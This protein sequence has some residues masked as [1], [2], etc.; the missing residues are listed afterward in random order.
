MTHADIEADIKNICRFMHVCVKLLIS[1][2]KLR[3]PFFKYT[4]QKLNYV[5]KG[6]DRLQS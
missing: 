3:L 1:S 2:L 5:L 4:N 6:N